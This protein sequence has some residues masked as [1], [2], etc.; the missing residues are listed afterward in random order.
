[1]AIK[2]VFCSALPSCRFVFANGVVAE[3]VAGEFHTDEE[4]QISELQA[5]VDRKHP[6]LFRN[7]KKLEVDTDAIDPIEAIKQK[8]VADFIAEQKEKE[9][10]DF[11][12]YSMPAVMAPS[13][14]GSTGIKTTAGVK[15][16]IQKSDSGK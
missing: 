3:F 8:A 15:V 9:G 13:A 11:G 1:M 16:N 12:N 4:Y 14:D 7:P 5:E 2:Q 6:N 10:R